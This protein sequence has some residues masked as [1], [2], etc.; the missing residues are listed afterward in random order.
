MYLIVLISFKKTVD[1]NFMAK[2]RSYTGEKGSRNT[3]IFMYIIILSLIDTN[4]V[5]YFV[6]I[7]TCTPLACTFKKLY[8]LA[9]IQGI[10]IRLL[11]E[12]ST[13]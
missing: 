3:W 4:F 12:N 11:S 6:P 1:K 10:L 2:T 8:S 7:S 13:G 5:A 9:R